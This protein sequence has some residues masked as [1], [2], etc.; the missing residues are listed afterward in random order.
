MAKVLFLPGAGGSDDFWRPVADRLELNQSQVFFSWPGLGLE[1]A[2]PEV[3]GLGDL[4]KMVAS[5]LDEPCDVIAQSIGG[6]VA[7]KAALAAPG[8]VRRLV[9]AATSAGLPVEE[10]GGVDWREEYRETYPDAAP[11]VTAVRE[12]L[13]ARLGRLAIPTLLLWGQHDPISPPAVGKRWLDLLPEARL[14]IISGGEH[15]FARTHAAQ[16]AR[17]IQEHLRSKPAGPR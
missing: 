5:E 17:L 16:T 14:R 13:S 2:H 8:A 12:D 11:W 9:L 7:V 3:Q 15:D 6:L 1:P 4:V 10:L